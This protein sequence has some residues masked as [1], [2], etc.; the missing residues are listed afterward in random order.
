MR[1]QS[2]LPGFLTRCVRTMAALLIVAA[3]LP[4]QERFRLGD[5]Q[6]LS[7][8]G[9]GSFVDPR[10]GGL[11]MVMAV[12]QVGG[13]LPIPV[14]LRVNGQF[15]I[16]AASRQ[17]WEPGD[18]AEPPP[19][20]K[21]RWYNSGSVD[22]IR[23]VY[24]TVHLGYIVPC[25]RYDGPVNTEFVV[26]EDGTQ[27]RTADFGAFTTW[28]STF[29]LPEDF[30]FSAKAPSQVQ[31]TN[32]GSHALYQ[33]TSVELGPT[34]QT[35]VQG[36]IPTGFGTIQDAYR[37]LMDKDRARVFVRLPD[38]NIWVPVLWADRFNHW[39]GMKWQR[40]QTGL[41]VGITATYSVEVR[42]Q[43]NQGVLL[44]WADFSAQDAVQDLLRADFIGVN[45]PCIL[46]RGYPGVALA[47]PEG[48]TG[49]NPM[50][51]ATVKVAGPVGRP[52]SVQIGESEEIPYCSWSQSAP[53]AS[54]GGLKMI[55]PRGTIPLRTWS[56][57]YD[58][59]RVAIKSMTDAM[60]VRTT[61][62]YETLGIPT[63]QTLQY[64]ETIGGERSRY[65]LG[66]LTVWGVQKTLAY[67]GVTAKTLSRSWTRGTAST[68]EPNVRFKETFGNLDSCP[69]WTE[70]LYAKSTDANGRDY[71]NGALKESRLWESDKTVPT[72]ST[73]Y[74]LQGA[75]LDY[76]YSYAS[77]M[78]VKRSGEPTR[79][80]A[81][82]L[83]SNLVETIK[84]SKFIGT[85]AVKIQETSIT[86]ETKKDKLDLRRPILTAVTRW[87]T[88]AGS[89]AIT[90]MTQIEYDAKGLPIKA[91]RQGTTG[92]QGSGF[93]YDGDGRLVLQEPIPGGKL[94][95]TQAY[96][97]D[98]ATG[99]LATQTTS[100]L[101]D[102]G[103]SMAL[104]SRTLSDFDSAGRP[105]TVTDERGLVTRQVFDGLGR[106][107]ET[108]NPVGPL[109]S[110][111][112][113]T[114][115]RRVVT[116]GSVS[117]T[118][119]TDGFG[120]ITKRTRPDGSWEE[121][122][123]DDFGRVETTRRYSRLG[124]PQ[125]PATT[126]YDALDRP[127]AI[128]S[129]GGAFQ[130]VTYAV[131]PAFPTR[132]L[133]TRTLN[134]PKTFATTKE[135]RDGLGQVV[136]Q[137][138]PKGDITESLYDGAG[139]L[140]KVVLTP[141]GNGTPQIRE[142]EY[143]EW[144][145]MVQ[146]KEPETG[147][148]LFK[149]FNW[150]GKPTRIEE[151]GG[152][153]R[154]LA[155]D[156]LGRLVQMESGK[157][158][159][160]YTF[161]GA[162]LTSMSSLSDG[163]EI[164]Q[165]FEYS[166]Q[167]KQ[168]SLEETVQPGQTSQINYSYD[169][170]TGLLK[171]LTY[172]NGR[173]IEYGRDGLGRV[174]G[175]L[176]NGSAIVSSVSFDEWGNRQRLGFASGAYS[177]WSSKNG[178]THL[179]QWSIGYNNSLLD[180]T[181]FYQYDS[182]ERLTMAGDWDK[183]E[184]DEQGRLVTANSSSLGINTTHGHDAYGNNINHLATGNV[185]NGA[186]NNFAFNSLPSNRL[187]GLTANGALTGWS[188]N[189]RGEATQIGTGTATNQY[190]GLGWDGFGRLK[191]VSYPS[192][193]QSYVYAPSG[194]RVAVIDTATANNRHYVYTSRGILLSEYGEAGAVSGLRTLA[195][196]STATPSKT[197]TKTSKTVQGLAYML[198]PPGED[199][200]PA[201]A[202]I[203]QPSGPTTVMVGQSVTF[204]GSTDYGTSFRWTFGDGTAAMT[205]TATKAFNA[206]GTYNVI[207]RASRTGFVASTASVQITVVPAGPMIRSFAASP[208]TIGE[209]NSTTLSWDVGGAT[210][211]SISGIGNVA[212]TGSSPVGPTSSVTYTLT[213][214][215]SGRTVTS[216][217]VVNVVPAP[218][219]LFFDSTPIS[220][221]G[222]VSTL[223][224]LVD[225]ATSCELDQGIGPVNGTWAQVWP[226]KTMTFRLT[227]I[228]QVNGIKVSRTVST[229][230]TVGAASNAVWKRD[231]IYLGSEPVA[232]ID[233]DGVHELHNDHLGSP[234]IITKGSTAQIEGRQVFGPYGEIVRSEGYIPLTG[235]TGHIRQDTTGLIYMRGRFYSPAWHRFLNSDQGVDPLSWNQ[236]AYVGGSPFHGK[237]PSGLTACHILYMEVSWTEVDAD[238]KGA[239][240][241]VESYELFRWCDGGGG[242]GD[243]G[244]GGGGGG[245]NGDATQT[246][247]D[248]VKAAAARAQSAINGAKAQLD[249]VV[250]KSNFDVWS[251]AA[252]D[253]VSFMA[254]LG[255]SAGGFV[256]S[257]YGA[258]HLARTASAATPS[259]W[260]GLV[261]TGGRVL[262]YLGA[263]MGVGQIWAGTIGVY[264]HNSSDIPHALNSFSNSMNEIQRQFNNEIGGC[265]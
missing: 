186:M 124:T 78:V 151:A 204:Q 194:M 217:V 41:P 212:A 233:A 183:L 1:V 210:S 69:R 172:P 182:A 256:G 20:N 237:D 42:N 169:P 252:N 153:V 154:T 263:A 54:S 28:N 205:A 199:P 147:I 47:R 65:S 260:P 187:P 220:Q 95:T 200:E 193:T 189:D 129:P 8:S 143:D 135:Y 157:E 209:G 254:S 174:T 250:N 29:T 108:Q 34:W 136:R 116:K 239:T 232:E 265:K 191:A 115:L 117:V 94:S 3:T 53:P 231:V 25:S 84:E 80:V 262:G 213:A 96:G 208:S 230:V 141:S 227:A 83:G 146:R 10:T 258:A 36:L 79:T 114:A 218:V 63:T 125:S 192:G 158:K 105:Q 19:Y 45:A 4:G 85:P 26:L 67:D 163:V 201:G 257:E 150:A 247:S 100:Y 82:L 251:Q 164:K 38:L 245:G 225:N 207:F 162:D 89:G 264:Y 140:T 21:P 242:S 90:T 216:S 259:G 48:T 24:G 97:Y 171:T 133:T 181:R 33:A 240:V 6:A 195:A 229:T 15:K 16:Q 246:K 110:I 198:P 104:L 9:S 159:I 55:A 27:F 178:G 261:M 255:V 149:D 142:F 119:E 31:V 37:V 166:G 253:S 72:A 160:T 99:Q 17:T 57:D 49:N 128:T 184:H 137:E 2:C 176:N 126:L 74:T 40:N 228:N 226:G 51:L 61:Y 206:V 121:T 52:T 64:S 127:S 241:H 175:I 122:T 179:D 244:G 173:N 211:V 202:W 223:R 11:S 139:N 87:G 92:Q 68:G 222:Q 134:T 156:G 190:L 152:R 98:S 144:G 113:P 102:G 112:Y 177:D 148:T 235:Y 5:P 219:I 248:C 14:A 109:T 243:G 62:T 224:W 167:G 238:G 215:G 22:V 130:S 103:S 180:G 131:D 123:Y 188:V 66:A 86:Y 145:R 73:V 111:S 93:S 35:K 91:Y 107:I 196:S 77:G 75:G 81:N 249:S 50:M 18:P 59:N 71:G 165:R 7:A 58:A 234:L 30:G 70:L 106:V 214:T 23:P 101:P 39:V 13:E 76:T 43:R 88:A 236:M 120:R 118:E 161:S 170:S 221:P 155:Y 132:S 32:L 203:D 56:F 197:K 185:P 168:L 46:V 44:S 60:G 138:S 12:G